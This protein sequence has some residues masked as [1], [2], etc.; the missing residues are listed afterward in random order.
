[1]TRDLPAISNISNARV[2]LN[3]GDSVTTDHISPAGAISRTSPAAKYLA[4][5]GLKPRDYNRYGIG[6]HLA[7]ATCLQKQA[8]KTGFL[9][10]NLYRL[11]DR[12]FQ[13]R[14]SD[15]K[16]EQFFKMETGF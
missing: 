5:R 3:L 8:Q 10:K 4:E 13:G 6:S 1:M 14:I 16:A 7:S 2:L 9:A 15:R 11:L 12:N